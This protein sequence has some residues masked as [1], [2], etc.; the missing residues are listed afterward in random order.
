MA[1][2][3]EKKDFGAGMTYGWD[4]MD[5]TSELADALDDR[6]SALALERARRDGR[7]TVIAS[8]IRHCLPLA[9]RQLLEEFGEDTSVPER[10]L[11]VAEACGA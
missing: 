1:D 10:R 7:D 6:V 9:V 8:D 11:G 5:L 2:Y 4:A 3:V